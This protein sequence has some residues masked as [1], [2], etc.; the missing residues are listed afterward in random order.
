M[1][2]TQDFMKLQLMIIMFNYKNGGAKSWPKWPKSWPRSFRWEQ[3]VAISTVAGR[4]YTLPVTQESRVKLLA[5]EDDV[6]I[7]NLKQLLCRTLTSLKI[8]CKYSNWSSPVCHCEAVKKNIWCKYSN[9]SSPVCHS[10]AITG[11]TSDGWMKD[12]CLR[13]ST[14]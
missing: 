14:N 9:W 7:D 8:W 13:T 5:R 2:L 10:E 1:M 11:R 3:C 12:H 4:K 6:I